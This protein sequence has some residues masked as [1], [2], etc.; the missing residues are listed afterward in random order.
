MK[1]TLVRPCPKC[2]FRKDCLEGWLGETR[3]SEIA[4]S[5]L[6]GGQ[7]FACHE[8]THFAESD[9]GEDE[10]APNGDEQH[11]VGAMILVDKEGAPNQMLQIAERLNLRDPDIIDAAAAELVFDSEGDFV[12]HHTDPERRR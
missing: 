7:T 12:E 10:Y 1:F 5:L 4:R 9:D 6:M 11:C 3:A 2:P 8:T